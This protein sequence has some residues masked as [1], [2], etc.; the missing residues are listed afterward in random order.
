MVN[1]EKLWKA[2]KAL[3]IE[4]EWK[5]RDR[6]DFVRLVCPLDIDGITEEGL[7]FT[8]TAYIYMPDRSVAF[9]I[10][11][12]SARNAK[13]RGPIVRFEWLPRAAHNNKGR[14]PAELRFKPISGSHIHPFDL[15]W[16]PA[17]LAMKEP[18]LPI[19]LPVVEPL[20]TYK[21]ALDFVEKEFRIKGVGS[22][23]PPPWTTKLI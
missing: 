15:N 7:I 13:L 20:S 6:N 21:Q 17:N 11:Y 19:A 23:P 9:Q 10:E 3:S 16:D 5:V 1:L 22:I 2:E 8:A 14:G 18:N 4:P 12:H